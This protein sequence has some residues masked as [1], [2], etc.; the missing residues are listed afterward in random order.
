MIHTWKRIN[1]KGGIINYWERKKDIITL[2]KK[3]KKKK[4]KK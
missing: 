3:K 2:V 1:W 4:K